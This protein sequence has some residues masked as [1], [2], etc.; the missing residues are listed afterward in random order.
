M[1]TT[2]IEEAHWFGSSGFTSGVDTVWM[3]VQFDYRAVGIAY[4]SYEISYGPVT[5]QSHHAQHKR[6][7]ST[8]I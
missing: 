5:S 2:I 6:Y 8:P 7:T 4:S 1:L 3:A